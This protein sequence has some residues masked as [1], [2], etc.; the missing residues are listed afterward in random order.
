MSVQKPFNL[1]IYGTLMNRSVFRAV[2]GVRLARRKTDA[3]GVKAFWARNAVLGGYQKV[4]PD[5]TY[6]YAVPAPRG[7]I[8]GYLLGPLPGQCMTALRQYEGQNYYRKKLRVQTKDG[9]EEAVVFLG[10]LEQ[11]KHSFGYEFRDPLKQEILLGEKIEAALQETEREQLHTQE[12]LYR[13][14]V[15]ELHGATIRDLVRTHFEGGGI[16]DYTIRHSLL[17]MPLPDFERIREDPEAKALA[18]NYLAMVVRQVI[19][20][21]LEDRVRREFR[22]ELD[23]M[24]PGRWYYERTISSLVVL[25]YLNRNASLL[26]MLVADCL[27]DLSF[28]SDHLVDFV[29]WSVV[30]ADAM[31]EADRLKRHLQ[32]IRNH[33]GSGYLPLGAELEFSNIGHDVIR[34]PKGRD[35]RDPKY[36]GFLYFRDFAL[37]VLTWKLGGHVDDH[38]DKASQS[39]RRGFFEVAM[40]NISIE[41]DLSK[42][43]TSDPWLLSQLITQAKRFYSVG[44]HSVHISLQLRSQH[45]PMQDRLLPL[46]AMKCL[47]AI[48]GDPVR[49]KDKRLRI[50]RLMSDEIV[51]RGDPPSMMF[52][53]IRK[54]YSAESHEYY[55]STRTPTEGGRYV[56]QFRFVRLSDDLNYEPVIMALKGLQLSLRPGSF[57][58]PSQYT[59]SGK[60][61]KLFEDLLRWAQDATPLADDEI[62]AFLGHIHDG[63]MGE[64]RGKPA[65]SEAYIAW[66]IN[67][68][69]KTLE[70]F[71]KMASV[72]AG[73]G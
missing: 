1:F 13:R 29:R 7:R 20:N 45:R 30:A 63:L 18:P 60:H 8:R 48:A 24:A 9:V 35:L 12:K 49:G 58:T 17:D 53:E 73:T 42:P 4:S 65:H 26:D 11:M 46:S 72:G 32:F 2:L 22:Y 67:Q 64:Q 16:S 43:L 50:N 6:L 36:D 68:L 55:P 10:N 47:F 52:S 31:Y 14:A 71:N 38:H 70:K 62:E 39:R 37:D 56:Q 27:T 44:P 41:A 59:S 21:Q 28:D 23:H 51:T 40:G 57:L 15:G 66:A 69:R 33:L 54:R 19:F 3:D 34:D 25:R 5:S 61:R